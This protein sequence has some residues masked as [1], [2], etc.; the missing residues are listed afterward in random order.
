MEILLTC[1]SG[2]YKNL[3][4]KVPL[5]VLHFGVCFCVTFISLELAI[6]MALGRESNSFG[7]VK[8]M[9]DSLGN[10]LTDATGI[11]IAMAFNKLLF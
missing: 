11:I 1:I 8:K 3:I 6:G 5:R 9:K 7:S 10:L 2:V 4:L